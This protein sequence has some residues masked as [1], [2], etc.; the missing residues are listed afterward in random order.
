M[1]VCL[2]GGAF[3]PRLNLIARIPSDYTNQAVSRYRWR[4]LLVGGGGADGALEAA[5][6][7]GAEVRG[8][9]GSFRKGTLTR[10]MRSKWSKSGVSKQG[11][12][13]LCLCLLTRSKPEP[14]CR[15]PSHYLQR[16]QRKRFPTTV[17][18]W[19]LPRSLVSAT[20][21]LSRSFAVEDPPVTAPCAPATNPPGITL[22]YCTYVQSQ[23]VRNDTRR[24]PASRLPLNRLTSNGL[25]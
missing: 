21:H 3:Y 14:S 13:Y 17:P 25:E 20:D 19:T 22:V 6:G 2:I 10:L 11:T 24:P 12:G 16:P 1:T 9:A 5:C 23:H 4:I 15:A 18:R 7:L 8:P